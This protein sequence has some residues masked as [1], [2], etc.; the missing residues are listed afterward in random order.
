MAAKKAAGSLWGYFT[1]DKKDLEKFADMMVKPEQLDPYLTP[2]GKRA[3]GEFLARGSQ[4]TIYKATLGGCRVA[5]K[6][7]H[8]A[9]FHG[10]EV[11]CP[12]NATTMPQR[13]ARLLS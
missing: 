4:G 6:Q 7:F 10:E 2:E 9:T 3:P 11:S 12:L 13:S 1:G 5:V 8:A